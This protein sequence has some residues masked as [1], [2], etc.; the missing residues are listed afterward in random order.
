MTIQSA[1]PQETQKGG[2]APDGFSVFHT[3]SNSTSL[4]ESYAGIP[5]KIDFKQLQTC[6]MVG[7]VNDR[8]LRMGA[9]P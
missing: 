5:E 1:H 4:P 9:R 6:W 7:L 8:A 2:P 3:H